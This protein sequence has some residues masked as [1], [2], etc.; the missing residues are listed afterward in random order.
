MPFKIHVHDDKWDR[1]VRE[2]R[3][4]RDEL[5]NLISLH[6]RRRLGEHAPEFFFVLEDSTTAGEETRPHSHGSIALASASLPAAGEGSRRLREMAEGVGQPKA[7]IE[8][9]RLLV[10]Q[11]LKAAAGAR[12]PRIAATSGLDQARNVWTR[13]Q[14]YH[15]LFNHQY[16]DYAFRNTRRV[17]RTLGDNRFAMTNPLRGEARRLWN[18]IKFGEEALE[19]WPV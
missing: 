18:L 17:S 16:V 14:P 9:G 1:W 5:R 15:P 3:D 13:R 19:Q 4:T 2:G 6:L 10:K 8:A 11:A 7:E 12:A